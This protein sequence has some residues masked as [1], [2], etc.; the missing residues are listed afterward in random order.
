MESK[1]LFRD[2]V[3]CKCPDSNSQPVQYSPVA[4]AIELRHCLVILAEVV[5]GRIRHLFAGA[6]AQARLLARS[7]RRGEFH[8]LCFQRRMDHLRDIAGGGGD[9]A[10]G[11]VAGRANRLSSAAERCHRSRGGVGS[12]DLGRSSRDRGADACRGILLYGYSG[13]DCFGRLTP[14]TR[15]RLDPGSRGSSRGN[16]PVCRDLDSCPEGWP[17]AA[18]RI[19]GQSTLPWSALKS[20]L[21][22]AWW[23]IRTLPLPGPANYNERTFYVG[24]A[25]LLL[26]CTAIISRERW[27]EKL[28]LV[29][30]A[31]AGVT[32]AFG[33]PVI[34]WVTANVPPLNRATTAR[35]LLW[36]ELAVTVLAAF[37]LQALIDAPRR[38]R[39]A[40]IILAGAAGIALVA[41]VAVD[42]SMREIRTTLNHLRTGLSYEDPKII[43]MTSIGWWLIFTAL[44]GVALALFRWAGHTRMAAVAIVLIA[45]VDLLHFAHGYQPMLTP[46]KAIPAS[47][48]AV[49]YLQ[50]H[51]GTARVAGIGNT[52]TNDYDMVYG[53]H[54]AR[55][56]DPPQPSYR[57][58]RL[59]QLANPSQIATQPFQLLGLSPV[60]LKVMSLLRVRYVIAAPGEPPL[61]ELERSVVYRGSDA[62][63][64][65]NPASA[66][67]A[68]VAHRV[69]VTPNEHATLA[70]VSSGKSNPA[71]EAIVEGNQSRSKNLSL[72]TGS[73]SGTANVVDARNA[74]VV[75]HVQLA[76]PGLVVLNEAMAAGWSV[77]VDGF[78]RSALS[79]D[80]VMRGVRVPAGI[81][82]VVWRYRVPGLRLG[83]ALTGLGVLCL[84]ALGAWATLLRRRPPRRYRGVYR[85]EPNDKTSV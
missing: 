57:Y 25:A 27:R 45:T 26:A 33:F 31:V 56:Y 50:R 35:M 38:Q 53:L 16:A 65:E 11:L 64:Y 55:G 46:A 3:L 28:P 24:A 14:P 60:G 37:G 36:F 2:A 48:P 47:T 41:T 29:L 22:P 69:L 54:D 42:P 4:R 20:A 71:T 9:D 12:G 19:G 17:C 34:H 79:V 78:P 66:P 30:L 49:E 63:I 61:P 40:W 84:L 76:R 13:I 80:D 70:A 59:W 83:L 18:S 75:L 23:E 52:L 32:A 21:F 81:H 72:P 44:I 51:A 5:G 10:M 1:R 6:R 68:L 39:T 67:Q 15:K 7:P 62:T 74:T 58:F 85:A 43:S 8:A 73:N 82:S 77:T